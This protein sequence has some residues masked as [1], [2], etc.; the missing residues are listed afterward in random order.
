[1]S[2]KTTKPRRTNNPMV[3][4]RFSISGLIFFFLIASIVVNTTCE[5]SKAGIGNKLNTAKFAE[6]IGI[7]SNMFS[8]FA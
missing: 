7:K 4:I 2:I 5:P 6:I 3:W 1:M 8:G